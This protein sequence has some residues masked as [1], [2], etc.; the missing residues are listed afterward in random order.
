MTAAAGPATVR[1]P[2]VAGAFYPAGAEPC[3]D[4]VMRCLG[5]ARS[6]PPGEPKVLVA[7]HAGHVYSGAIAG[8]AYA[9]LASR[10]GTIRRVVMLGPAHRA[11]FSGMATTSVDSWASP[12]G[13][14][15][16][17][18]PA[19]RPLLSA[20]HVRV[21]DAVFAREHCLEVQLPFLQRVLEDFSI[22]PILVGDADHTEV[23][24]VLE[25]LWGGP[26]TLIL[27]SSDLSHFHDYETTRRLDTGTA[28]L[29][30][31]MRPEKIDAERACG[32]RALGGALERARALDLRVT[33][34]DVRNSGDTCGGK[35]RVVGYGAFA[36]EYAEQARLPDGDRARLL[37]AA[38]ASLTFGADNGRPMCAGLGAGLSPALTAMRASFIT[39][40][41]GGRL[42]GCWGSVTARAPL[43]LDVVANAY[44]AGFEDPRFGPVTADELADADLGISVLST[45]RPLRFADETDLVRQLRPD[46]DGLI[47]Q[48]GDNRGLF[49]PSV[50]ESV[51]RPAHF[52]RQLKRKAGLSP[53][54]WSES[55]SAF[56]F[57]AE[58]FSAPFRAG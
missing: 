19:L 4:L 52:V 35:D 47:L 21:D 58:S 10:R 25:A 24:R 48:E 8:T 17:D 12:L 36:M 32:Y 23:A 18:W 57:S 56:R 51:P 55:L 53:D 13:T 29:I 7:P 43:L 16:V 42:R 50:W 14:V 26:E 11:G 28:K 22:V 46:R 1:Q 40:R 3:A 2:E 34:L 54:H 31:L 45:P 39:L 33:A 5:G 20:P 44:K 37:G 27:I 30:E 6:S 9:P 15:A 49:L 41:T 38:R